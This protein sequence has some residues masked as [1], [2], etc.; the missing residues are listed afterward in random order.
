MNDPF[1]S[2]LIQMVNVDFVPTCILSIPAHRA[3]FGTAREEDGSQD[4]SEQ[5][6]S[7]RYLCWTLV[8]L[9]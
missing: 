6:N 2:T 5:C 4:V 1:L 8:F 7:N 3:C 9:S